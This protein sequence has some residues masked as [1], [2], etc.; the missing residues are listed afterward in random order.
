MGNERVVQPRAEMVARREGERGR[1]VIFPG[2]EGAHDRRID[3]PPLLVIFGDWAK[4][5]EKDGWTTAGTPSYPP[6]R[7]VRQSIQTTW[8]VFWQG[9]V[10]E[11]SVFIQREGPIN[12]A[13]VDLGL[14]VTKGHAL[15]C[16]QFHQGGKMGL[17]T[18]MH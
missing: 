7:G 14:D 2:T 15:V 16:L 8:Q 11:G 9:K 1:S 4:M 18:G 5:S 13:Q 10:Q 12:E 3:F 17:I 6:I